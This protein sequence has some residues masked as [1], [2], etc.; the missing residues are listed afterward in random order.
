M[1]PASANRAHK[2]F[3]CVAPLSGA[4]LS[5]AV[6]LFLKRYRDAPWH[7]RQVFITACAVFTGIVTSAWFYYL[8]SVLL[9]G[10][11]GL[12]TSL[13]FTL[14]AVGPSTTGIVLFFANRR[15]NVA[16]ADP[17]LAV[18]RGV[19]IRVPESVELS[20]EGAEVAHAA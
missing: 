1:E 17:T 9:Q 16:R 18:V 12:Q 11:Q 3:I 15:S 19:P 14:M 7:L 6:C 13:E 5:F 20:V 2:I 8:L 10:Q 4:V